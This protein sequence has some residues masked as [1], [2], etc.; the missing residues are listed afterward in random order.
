VFSGSQRMSSPRGPEGDPSPQLL[1]GLGLLV[2]PSFPRRTGTPKPLTYRTL[3]LYKRIRLALT[4]R[5]VP[6][7][8]LTKED[9]GCTLGLLGPETG[10]V[11]RRN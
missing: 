5:N 6:F 3:T 2:K 7:Q 4:R 8:V 11:T 1:I 10:L 9:I